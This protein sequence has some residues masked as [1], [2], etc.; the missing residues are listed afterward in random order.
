MADSRSKAS[1]LEAMLVVFLSLILSPAGNGRVSLRDRN[2]PRYAGTVREMR[3][4]G[5]N[6]DRTFNGEPYYHQPVLLDR[7]MWDAYDLVGDTPFNARFVP[8]LSGAATW[9]LVLA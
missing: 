1:M 5:E 6:V 2:V 4:C 9:V 7:M 3:D 8:T